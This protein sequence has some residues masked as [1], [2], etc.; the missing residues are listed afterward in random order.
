MILTIIRQLLGRLI[1]FLNFACPPRRKKRSQAEQEK[2]NKD[3]QKLALYQFYLC[4]FC[5]R[6]R[7]MMTRLNLAIECRDVKSNEKHHADLIAGGGKRK[8]PCLRIED[9]GKVTWLYESVAIN[10]Y[11]TERFGS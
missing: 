8:V 7:R 5:I 11:L 2:V 10:N 9:N 3:T 6:V 1:V 4:P